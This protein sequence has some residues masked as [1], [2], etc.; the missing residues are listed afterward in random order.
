MSYRLQL[1]SIMV[2]FITD[3]RKAGSREEMHTYSSGSIVLE[4]GNTAR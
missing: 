1:R 3:N 2:V 4:Y